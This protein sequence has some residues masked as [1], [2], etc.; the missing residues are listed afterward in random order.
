VAA[1]GSEGLLMRAEPLLAAEEIS[2]R[3]VDVQ[4]VDGALLLDADPAWA[5]AINTVLIMKGIR[6][7]ELRPVSDIPLPEEDR[8]PRSARPR[9]DVPV[10]QVHRL[11]SCAIIYLPERDESGE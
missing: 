6:V 11:P 1:K 2:R 7:N 4:V 10:M 5:G 3:M 9:S 8:S